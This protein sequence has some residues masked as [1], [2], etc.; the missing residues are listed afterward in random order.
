MSNLTCCKFECTGYFPIQ[1]DMQ[2]IY[3][4]IHIHTTPLL[5]ILA[6]IATVGLLSRYMYLVE[7]HIEHTPTT[8]K[9]NTFSYSF[10]VSFGSFSFCKILFNLHFTLSFISLLLMAEIP[11]QPPGMVLKPYKKWE[12]LPT[13]TVSFPDFWAINSICP[14]YQVTIGPSH[15]QYPSLVS[16]QHYDQRSS[17]HSTWWPLS[18]RRQPRI[19]RHSPCRCAYAPGREIFW[20]FLLEGQQKTW[21][22]L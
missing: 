17:R 5:Q 4:D 2:Y 3:I 22:F 16:P 9:K 15:R 1:Y 21:K 12:K 10:G 14:F 18:Y 20:R 11:K 19:P 6:R 7:I 8:A 13:S